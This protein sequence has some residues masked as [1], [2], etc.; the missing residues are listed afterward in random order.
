M[1]F[2]FLQK[3]KISHFIYYSIFIHLLKCRFF[4]KNALRK[5]K[6]SFVLEFLRFVFQKI[7]HD[8]DKFVYFWHF[9]KKQ[10]SFRQPL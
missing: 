9:T 3:K 4:E 7:F 10:K 5:S 2:Y 1:P 6:T 8:K